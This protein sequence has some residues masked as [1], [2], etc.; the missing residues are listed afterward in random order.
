[1]PNGYWKWLSCLARTH[2]LPSL[3][4]AKKAICL[5]LRNNCNI[6]ICRVVPIGEASVIIA[7][8]SAHRKNS[9]EAV[10]YCIDTLKATVPIWKKVV[11][12][13]FKSA[14]LK[15]AF[16]IY[17]EGGLWWFPYFLPSFFWSPPWSSQ[18]FFSDPPLKRCWFIKGKYHSPPPSPST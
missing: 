1:M 3:C 2:C 7:V 16:I 5:V 14:V 18:G 10:Q 9:L 11:F 17:L 4:C 13:Y 8:S 12:F 6:L 15:G